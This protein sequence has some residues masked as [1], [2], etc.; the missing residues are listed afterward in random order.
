MDAGIIILLLV[1]IFVLIFVPTGI[2]VFKQHE[3]G[4]VLR[5]GEPSRISGPGLALNIPFVEK[6]YKVNLQVATVVLPM[7]TAISKDNAG[8][9]TKAV[10][11]YKVIN[12]MAAVFRS[13]TYARAACSAGAV[14][15]SRSG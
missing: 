11:K 8:I 6:V 15:E 12:P 1:L 14:R 2:K 9:Q 4:V 5:M 7:Q 13:K 10:F 3:R